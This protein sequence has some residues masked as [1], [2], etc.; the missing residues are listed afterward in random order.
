LRALRQA[1]V[2][3]NKSPSPAPS[4]LPA[5]IAVAGLLLA[6]FLGRYAGRFRAASWI[7]LLAAA[8]FAMSACGSSSSTIYEN[9]KKGTYT[10]TLQGQDSLTANISNSTTF[11]FTIN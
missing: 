6:G 1:N 11:T 4:R 9:P 10:V 7:I 5:E 3:Q 8:A 2:S